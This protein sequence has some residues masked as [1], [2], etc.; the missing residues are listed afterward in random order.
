MLVESISG[1]NEY[2]LIEECNDSSSMCEEKVT[3]AST[4]SLY[5][6]ACEIMRLSHASVE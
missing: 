6:R 3:K 1:A 5:A 4:I 2:V